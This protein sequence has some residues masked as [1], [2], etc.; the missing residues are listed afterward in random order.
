MPVGTVFTKNSAVYWYKFSQNLKKKQ[1]A[2]SIMDFGLWNRDV[3]TQSFTVIRFLLFHFFSKTMQAW[4]P[5]VVVPSCHNT[6]FRRIMA[7]K[8][9]KKPKV[10]AFIQYDQT[11][12]LYSGKIEDKRSIRLI[13]SSRFGIFNIFNNYNPWKY[14][15]KSAQQLWELWFWRKIWKKRMGVNDK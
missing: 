3:K 5:K 6:V 15:D 14:D 10:G 7:F 12:W 11:L 9:V 1:S 2:F 13:E 8:L 4:G